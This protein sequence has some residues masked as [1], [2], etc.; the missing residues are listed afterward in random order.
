MASEV[1]AEVEATL[2]AKRDLRRPSKYGHV[3][4]VQQAGVVAELES[5][6]KSC[7]AVVAMSAPE[8]W[9]DF[10]VNGRVPRDFRPI[11]V[12]RMRQKKRR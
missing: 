1:E 7:K 2:A 4:A 12:T 9:A 11:C 3:T 5:V 8:G 10:M 6:F